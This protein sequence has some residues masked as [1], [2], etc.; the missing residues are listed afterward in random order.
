MPGAE[1]TEG[2]RQSLPAGASVVRSFD[3]PGLYPVWCDGSGQ[4]CG[5]LAVAAHPQFAVVEERRPAAAPLE[6]RFT[7]VSPA[8][9][10]RPVAVY[11]TRR[12]AR[13]HAACTLDANGAGQLRLDPADGAM[14]LATLALNGCRLVR[15]RQSPVAHACMRGG[16]KEA[17]KAMKS[18]VNRA[19]RNGLKFECDSCHRNEEN[20]QLTDDARA[21]FTSMLAAAGT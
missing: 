11:Q 2:E 19:R 13:G 20:W 14:P 16:I 10:P 1:F 6:V 15:D 5:Y 21:N 8:A 12:R 9:G 17:K 3:R 4:P 18:L 7:G